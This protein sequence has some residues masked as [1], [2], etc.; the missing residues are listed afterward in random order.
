MKNETNKNNVLKGE[1]HQNVDIE[2]DQ[3]NENAEKNKFSVRQ[4]KYK[5]S[6]S[7][8][9]ENKEFVSV[10]FIKLTLNQKLF[11]FKICYKCKL[12]N[13]LFID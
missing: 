13:N 9:D 5:F 12:K 11:Y 4:L 8:F 10:L 6:I 3:N 7:L 2:N 1:N